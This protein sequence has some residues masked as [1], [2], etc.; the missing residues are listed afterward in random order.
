M[1]KK[2]IINE[3]EGMFGVNL[4]KLP[5]AKAKSKKTSK[6]TTSKKKK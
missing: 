2:I 6:K 3:N 1:S 4:S 5:K